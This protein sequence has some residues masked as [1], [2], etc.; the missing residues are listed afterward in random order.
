VVGTR[1]PDPAPCGLAAIGECTVEDMCGSAA[2]G[3][4]GVCRAGGFSSIAF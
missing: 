3:T 2:V 4:D 1:D